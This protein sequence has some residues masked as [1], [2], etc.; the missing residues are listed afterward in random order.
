MDFRR[1]TARESLPS[2]A[3]VAIAASIARWFIWRAFVLWHF[4]AA[5][6]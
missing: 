5:K 6:D 3:D 4:A 1:R 2:L